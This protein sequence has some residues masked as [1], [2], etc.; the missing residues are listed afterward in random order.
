MLIELWGILECDL[1]FVIGRIVFCDF[2]KGKC[3]VFREV[4]G[5]VMKYDDEDGV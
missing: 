5:G 1:V 3:D 4:E 2:I